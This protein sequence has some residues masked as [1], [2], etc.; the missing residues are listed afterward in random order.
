M[1]KIILNSL[2][3]LLAGVIIRLHPDF[4]VLSLVSWASFVLAS[5]ML[6]EQ[7]WRYGSVAMALSLVY[8][9]WFHF[10]VLG[11]RF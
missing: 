3:I 9:G 8:N 10:S 2:V 7:R 11:L 5:V 6:Y 4:I 1:G